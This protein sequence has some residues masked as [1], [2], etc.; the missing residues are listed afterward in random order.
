MLKIVFL[1]LFLH[2]IFYK[3][4]I[5]SIFQNRDFCYFGVCFCKMLLSNALWILKSSGLKWEAN[6]E[7]RGFLFKIHRRMS[8]FEILCSR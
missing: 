7:K 3:T 5:I 6:R 8:I 4:F 2:R 1:R